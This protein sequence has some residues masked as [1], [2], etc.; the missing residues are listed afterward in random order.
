MT[1]AK[2]T[3]NSRA[4][5]GVRTAAGV[6]YIKPDMT[7]TLEFEDH[8]LTRAESRPMLTVV[9]LDDAPAPILPVTPVV[10]PEDSNESADRKFTA[11]HK[12]AGKFSIFDGEG[13]EVASG[14]SKADAEA[15]NAMSDQDKAEYVG[16]VPTEQ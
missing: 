16:I 12:G 9:R 1:R 4:L 13:E 7:R 2:V 11:R 3:N 10:E 5:Q 15:F 8:E 6:V 14:L